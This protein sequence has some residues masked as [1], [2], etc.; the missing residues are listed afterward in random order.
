M[1]Y[2]VLVFFCCQV[3]FLRRIHTHTHTQKKKKKRKKKKRAP[4]KLYCIVLYF[5]L[6]GQFNLFLSI[7]VRI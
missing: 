1:F 5:I 4:Q 6:T 7:S 3:N 2:F